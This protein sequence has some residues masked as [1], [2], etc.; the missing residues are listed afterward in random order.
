MYVYYVL[1]RA[2][3]LRDAQ[4]M[5]MEDVLEPLIIFKAIPPYDRL[6]QYSA[7]FQRQHH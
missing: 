2:T 6:K 7:I 3:A 4:A 5:G 1:E